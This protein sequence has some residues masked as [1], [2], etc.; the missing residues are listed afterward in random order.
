MVAM[1]TVIRQ[2]SSLS[3]IRLT[4]GRISSGDSVMPRKTLAAAP[5]LS[6]ELSPSVRRMALLRRAMIHGRMR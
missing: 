4:Y 6:A 5:T 1:P 3:V 2:N